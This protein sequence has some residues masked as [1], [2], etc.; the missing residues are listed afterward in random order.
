MNSPTSYSIAGYGEMIDAAPRTRAYAQALREAIR[1]GCVV[2]D[3]G[4]GTGIFSLLACQFG[5]GHVHAVEPDNAIQVARQMAQDNGLLDRITF[6]QRLSSDVVLPKRVDVI[7][8]DLRGVVPLFQQH[9]PTTID[10]R[11]RLLAPQGRLIPQQDTLWAALIESPKLYRPYSDP[12][13]GNE[14]GLDL[15]ASHPLMVNTWC[16]TR[17]KPQELFGSPQIWSVLDYKS[18][19]QSNVSGTLSWRPERAGTAHGLAVWFDAELTSGV[20][21]SNAPSEPELIYGQAF[22][23]FEQPIALAADDAISVEL[24]ANLINGDYVWS[25]NTQAIVA[26]PNGATS[27]SSRQSTFFGE[28]LSPTLLKRREARFVPP[29]TERVEIDRHCLAAVNNMATLGEI[30]QTLHQRFPN[31]FASELE[32]L[33]YAADLLQHDTE[34]RRAND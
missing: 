4:A 31:R 23:P 5:A 18:L 20:G 30:A 6:H 34:K 8:S 11:E 28:P 2:L 32:A 22:F 3:I 14:Y 7:V 12:W 29:L 19:Q 9:L 33:T 1:P 17:I 27:I 13:L 26:G 15:S 25:W 24:N 10:A 16:K 21:F